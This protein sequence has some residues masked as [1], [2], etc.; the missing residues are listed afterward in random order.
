MTTCALCNSGKIEDLTQQKSFSWQKC[1]DCSYAFILPDFDVEDG[2]DVL[3]VDRGNAYIDF[4]GKKFKSKMRRA[5]KRAAF[6]KKQT[7]GKQV[8]DVGCNLG[9]F[10]EACRELDM[11]AVGVEVSESV[12]EQAK[13]YFPKSDFI[14]DFLENIDFEDQRFDVVYTSE[15]LEHVPDVNAFMSS[16]ATN[17]NNG[18]VLYL[19]TPELKGYQ[20]NSKTGG[21]NNLHAPN[22]RQYFSKD[23]I[24]KFLKKHGFENI[25]LLRNWN[26]KPGIKLIAF[27]K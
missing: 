12:V 11:Q 7:E 3:S 25:R 21:W 10:V 22:H 20:N 23:N 6:L 16:I 1:E 2:L 14:C 8:L 15:V 9:Y 24:V 5:R 17:M 4:Y 19:T 26:L 13:E 27:K 18:G